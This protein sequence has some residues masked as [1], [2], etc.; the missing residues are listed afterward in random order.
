V[1]AEASGEKLAEIA[2]A[3]GRELFVTVSVADDASHV[4]GLSI[5][6][7]RAGRY[8]ADVTLVLA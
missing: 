3:N 8:P 6:S 2:Q 4:G 7:S 5:Y 1:S